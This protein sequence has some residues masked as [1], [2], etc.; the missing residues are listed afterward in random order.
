MEEIS[1]GLSDFSGEELRVGARPRRAKQEPRT[2]M[3][4]LDRR[5]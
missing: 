5:I 2:I 1:A 4:Q 3:E